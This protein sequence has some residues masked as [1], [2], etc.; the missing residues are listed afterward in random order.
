MKIAIE[1]GLRHKVGGA[2]RVAINTLLAMA[3]QRPDHDYIV[4]AIASL[5]N[6]IRRR[7][8]RYCSRHVP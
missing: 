3:K 8:Y 7:S 5:N 1:I 2:R 6:L 4:Y